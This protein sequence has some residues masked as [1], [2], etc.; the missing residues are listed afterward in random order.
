MRLPGG[1]RRPNGGAES[2]ATAAGGQEWEI[3]LD[4]ESGLYATSGLYAIRIQWHENVQAV[5]CPTGSLGKSGLRRVLY[6]I[7]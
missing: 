6:V 4:G 2:P 1:V 7:C 3:G 5:A